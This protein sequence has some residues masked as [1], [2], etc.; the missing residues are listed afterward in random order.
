MNLIKETNKLI[1]Q[2]SEVSSLKIEEAYE[3]IRCN[4]KTLL[5]NQETSQKDM[6]VGFICLAP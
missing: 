5:E 4:I 2:K 3:G 1:S 6:R